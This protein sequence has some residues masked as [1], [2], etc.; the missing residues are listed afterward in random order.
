MILISQNGETYEIRFPYDAEIVRRI[1]NVPGR[2]WDPDGKFW[3][4][5]LARL[6][7]LIAQFKN[8]KYEN[9]LFIKSNEDINVNLSIDEPNKIP[10]IDISDIKVY[11]KQ[12]LY[13]FEHQKD[14]LKFAKW[15][16]ENG[17]KSGF[18][19]ADE[20]GCI[21]GHALVRIREDHKGWTNESTLS[22]VYK[23]FKSGHY[24]EIKTM[25]NGRF[26]YKPIADVI[27]KGVRPV[28]KIST[29][30]HSIV[31]TSDHEIY[32]PDGW[33]QACDLHV[34]NTVM[35]NGQVEY[36]YGKAIFFDDNG[37]KITNP[38]CPRCGST[39][40]IVREKGSKFLRYC[41]SCMYK[42]RSGKVYKDTDPTIHKRIDSDGYVR[43]FGY[44]LRFHPVRE[45][46]DIGEGIYEHHYVWY[47]HTGYLIDTSKEAI[48]HKNKIKTDNRFENLQLVTHSEH[49]RIHL[50]DSVAHLPQNHTDA[51]FYYA[52]GV[53]VMIV[54]K[55]DKIVSIEILDEPEHVYDITIADA[56]VH[57]FICNHFI[58]HN[59]G[60]TLSVTNWAMYLKDHYQAK[61]CLIIAC[62]N[63]AKYNWRADIIKHT[64][65]EEVPYI[66]GSRHKR[67][68]SINSDVGSKEKLED[69]E[70]MTMYKN[71]AEP[72]PYFL[73]INIEAIRMRVGKKYPIADRIVELINL[74]EISLIALDE[75]HR[76]ASMSSMQGKQILRVKKNAKNQIQWIPM[77]G[78]PIV[79]KPTDV[80][81]PLRLVDGHA[82]DSYWSWCQK[83]CMYGGFGGHEIVGYKNIPQL[84]SILQPN[85]LRR[86]KRDILDL[87]PKIH[88]TEYIENTPYQ[89]KLYDKIVL[90][91]I[92]DRDN[93]VKSLNPLSQFLHLR[94]VNGSPELVDSTVCTNSK[95][96]LS[97][98]AKLKRLLEILDDILAEPGEKV[99]IFSNWVEPLRTLH[100]YINGR[101]K[102][103][104]YTGTMSPDEREKHK[105]AFINDPERRIMIG[106]IGAL[107]TSH[108]LTVARN[109]IFYDSPWNPADIRQAEDRCHRPGTTSSVF[110]YSLITKDTVDEKVHEILSRKEGTANYIV[111]NE[112]DLRSHPELFDLLLKN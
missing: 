79:S 96:Y 99:V 12:G 17:L 53:K 37:N 48:H 43:L 80:F 91:M 112:L 6:G 106:T 95:D 3:S 92:N 75:I 47:E 94:Q 64:N 26:V 11:V 61:H 22:N 13:L 50:E 81:L 58:V 10:D 1:K 40:N 70:S 67:D 98:N 34:G 89:K 88:Y 31:C 32:T 30:E 66:I 60:K 29:K 9:Q 51:E 5:P 100:R 46:Y 59:C 21:S 101:Y 108:T 25:E 4:I 19:L 69:L 103:C 41:R 72:L 74:G 16:I 45:R 36:S 18:I 62:V 23:K 15:R 52:H 2:R 54:P 78:T 102:T 39:E 28:I 57:N 38:P 7:F 109:V 56:V 49:Q 86:L 85:M 105:K 107:G 93:I 84:K 87:P 35:M 44:P 24:L 71:Q 14:M 65:G 110:I 63:A 90:D 111:D 104:C 55:E 42:L 77:T 33:I 83:Y 27:D 20:P 97:K 82:S 73:I 68:G 76:N 8:T